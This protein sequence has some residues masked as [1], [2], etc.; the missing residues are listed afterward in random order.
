MS[1]K[2]SRPAS[3]ASCTRARERV[4]VGVV[5]LPRCG[6]IAAH[7]IRKRTAFMPQSTLMRR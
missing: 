7:V 6:S 5:E 1:T 3:V 2:T 4:E